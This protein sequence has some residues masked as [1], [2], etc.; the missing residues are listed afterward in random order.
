MADAAAI[1]AAGAAPP[2]AT[3][4]KSL[5]AFVQPAKDTISQILQFSVFI[6]IMQINLKLAQNIAIVQAV[7]AVIA[8]SIYLANTKIGGL[9]RPDE[10]V[11]Y[12]PSEDPAPPN[13]LAALM[14]GGAEEKKAVAWE[15]LTMA[16]LE[17]RLAAKREKTVLNLIMPAV[18]SWGMGIHYL[19]A[20]Q[21]RRSPRAPAPAR[22]CALAYFSPL[23]PPLLADH[24]GAAFVLR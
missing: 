8:S 15:R 18:L 2:A 16:A 23:S 21:V 20:S 6:V 11:V 24:P 12:Y 22:G 14:G 13:P 9:I 1:A 3:T 5:T 17:A 19:A 7:F 10:T 4:I